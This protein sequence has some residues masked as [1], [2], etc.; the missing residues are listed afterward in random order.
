M[1]VSDLKVV[2]GE[3][4]TLHKCYSSYIKRAGFKFTQSYKLSAVQLLT[5]KHYATS[6][7]KGRQGRPLDNLNSQLREMMH[8]THHVQYKH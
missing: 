8:D 3:V 2:V 4:V 5:S 1:P 7:C 6:D